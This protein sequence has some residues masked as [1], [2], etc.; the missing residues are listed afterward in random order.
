MQSKVTL[1]FNKQIIEEAKVYAES[2]NMSLSR[3]TEYLLRRVMQEHLH[4]V[5]DYPI[6]DW[7]AEIAE[8][9]AEYIT[10]PKSRRATKKD[11]FEGKK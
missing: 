7:V 9:R 2:Q 4:K 6:A 8:G 5:E 11:F 10:K 3:L 1:S